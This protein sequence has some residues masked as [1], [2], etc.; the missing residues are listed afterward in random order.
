M[1]LTISKFVGEEGVQATDG[2][3][4][5]KPVLYFQENVPKMKLASAADILLFWLWS[6]LMLIFIV[7]SAFGRTITWRQMRYKLLG[8]TE[9]IILNR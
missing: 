8:P 9:T 7:S 6:P 1:L 4:N 3:K 2:S 5:P